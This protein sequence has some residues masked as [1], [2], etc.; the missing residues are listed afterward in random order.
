MHCSSCD[1]TLERAAYSKSQAAKK[2]GRRCKE[3][4]AAATGEAA[5]PDEKVEALV[6]ESGANHTMP[7]RGKGAW[8][9]EA[10]HAMIDN[11]K[12]STSAREFARMQLAEPAST[13]N[14]SGDAP[15]C[16]ATPSSRS[17]AGRA[18]GAPAWSAAAAG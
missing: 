7:T 10:L 3:C 15:R 11:P 4:V 17:C 13:S 14:D 12:T 9:E 6:V 18:A 2:A 16:P 1:R 5:S 8:P